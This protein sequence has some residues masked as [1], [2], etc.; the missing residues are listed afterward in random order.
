MTD[1]ILSRYQHV[2]ESFTLIHGTS[3]VFDVRVNDELIYSKH[4][5]GRHANDGEVLGL[6]QEI[7]GP[8]MPIYGT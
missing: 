3:G 1:D 4:K 6:F 8:E 2:I 7:V 5:T